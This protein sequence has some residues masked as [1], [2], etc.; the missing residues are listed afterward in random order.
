MAEKR[1]NR[2]DRIAV[3][4]AGSYG[5]ALAI[6]FS[7]SGQATTLWGRDPDQVE[8]MATSRTNE[9]YL[10]AIEFP[11]A[12]TVTADL[13][14]T[15]AAADDVLIAVPSR[16]F[17]ELVLAIAAEAP[18]VAGLCWATKGFEIET[19]LL[20]HQVVA[21]IMPAGMPTAVL[22]G[23]TFAAEVARQLPSAMTVASKS[24]E[25]AH[26]LAVAISSD[27][28]RAYLSDDVIG[29]EVGGATKNIYAIGAGM[30]DGLGFGANTRV[31]L[32]TRGLAEMTRLGSHLGARIETFMGLAGMG[33]LVLTCT[34]DQSR[35]RRFGLALAR[36]Q[37]PDQARAQIGQVVEG[38]YAARAVHQVAAR[39]S[40][41]MPIAEQVYRILYE[42][43]D[44]KD[45]LAAL[46]RRPI[47]REH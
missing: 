33:D 38:Y 35:N 23:P 8:A 26:R 5:T 1:I 29:V 45:A 46:M 42:G 13:G 36:G 40:I 6:Q 4:G 31:A 32:L 16:S 18:D 24:E 20:P 2:A 30:T 19:G 28:F 21:E 11:A 27:N 14:A 25:F 9:R 3:L 39:E 12:L 17:R 34:D 15:L 44:P 22:S 43:L 7:R 47:M 10:P 41:D 37:T